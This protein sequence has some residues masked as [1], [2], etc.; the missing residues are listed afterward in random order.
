M[1]VVELVSTLAT[2]QLVDNLNPCFLSIKA[3]T[4]NLPPILVTTLLNT[5][6]TLQQGVP[7]Q[8]INLY[9]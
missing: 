9:I 4:I 5:M 3:V 8:E 2:K 1:S 6:T 7:E